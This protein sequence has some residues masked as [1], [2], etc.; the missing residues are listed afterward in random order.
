VF[1]GIEEIRALEMLVPYLKSGV[2][3]FGVYLDYNRTV[4]RRFVVKYECAAG[5][6]KST[7]DV[8]NA[9]VLNTKYDGGMRRIQFISF[10]GAGLCI[11]STLSTKRISASSAD[12]GIVVVFEYKKMPSTKQQTIFEQ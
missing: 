3:V 6:V 12:G 9:E 1:A 7:I 11:K 5:A 2:D 4:S 8:G 10:G